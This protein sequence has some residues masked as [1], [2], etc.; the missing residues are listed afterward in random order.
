M[1]IP[2]F[3]LKLLDRTIGEGVSVSLKI[4]STPDGLL[5][6]FSAAANAV[7]RHATSHDLDIKL[8]RDPKALLGHECARSKDP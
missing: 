3:G 2:V 5:P 7:W 1:S 4:A 6:V 8:Q